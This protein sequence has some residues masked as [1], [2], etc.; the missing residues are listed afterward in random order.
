MADGALMVRIKI[1]GLLPVDK[2]LIQH[3]GRVLL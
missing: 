1:G 3:S 2:C